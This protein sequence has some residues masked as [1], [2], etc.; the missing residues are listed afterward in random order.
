M[1]NYTIFM[2]NFQEFFQSKIAP[3]QVDLTLKVLV[4]NKNDAYF[5]IDSN[6]QFF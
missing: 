6:F 2:E 5:G 3:N 4:T 1:I